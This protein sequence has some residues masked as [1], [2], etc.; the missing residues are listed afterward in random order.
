MIIYLSQVEEGGETSFPK[1][2]LKVKA[3][4]GD[5]V[6]FWDMTPTGEVDDMSLHAGEQVVKG[7]KWIVVSLT[8]I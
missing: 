7:E 1:I 5:A 4:R 8:F 6:L 2:N 3:T